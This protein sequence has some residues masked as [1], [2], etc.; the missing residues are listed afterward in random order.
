MGGGEAMFFGEGHPNKEDG[1]DSKKILA[2]MDFSEP[3]MKAIQ[4]AVAL[5]LKF[6][7]T[8]VVAYIMSSPSTFAYAFPIESHDVIKQQLDEARKR[9]PTLI[10]GEF[11][12][13]LHSQ[14]A[15]K[16]GTVEDELFALVD[17][18]K[19]DLVVMGT[20][21]RRAFE[22]WFLGSTTEHMLRR[23]PVPVLTVSHLDPEHEIQGIVRIARRTHALRDGFFGGFESQPGCD[24]RPAGR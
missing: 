22:R 5:A 17:D 21:G 13:Q 11:R 4:Y 2:P 20:H 15:V 1:R 24:Q 6:R 8:L 3:S 10:P 12:E 19:I 9:M 23:L 16:A 7:A 18:E 14:F